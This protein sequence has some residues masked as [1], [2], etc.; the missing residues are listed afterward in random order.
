MT[1]M[2]ES[3]DTVRRRFLFLLMSGGSFLAWSILGCGTSENKIEMTPE[4]KKS[5]LSSKIGDPS[6]FIKPGRSTSGKSR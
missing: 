1:P 3:T 5:I 2:Q 4:T 6:K